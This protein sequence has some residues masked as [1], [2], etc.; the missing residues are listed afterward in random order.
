MFEERDCAGILLGLANGNLDTGGVSDD[1]L[2]KLFTALDKA[3]LGFVRIFE[4]A[5]KLLILVLEAEHGFFAYH[6]L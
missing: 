6:V 2:V 5:V 1:G 3:F 4:R